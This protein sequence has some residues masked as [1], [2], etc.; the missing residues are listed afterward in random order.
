MAYYET[1][2]YCMANLDPGERCDCQRTNVPFGAGNKK[3]P[4][5]WGHH[6]NQLQKNIYL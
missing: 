2:P 4:Q 6:A 3:G 5:V 1:C